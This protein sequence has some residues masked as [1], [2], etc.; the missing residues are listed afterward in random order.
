MISEVFRKYLMCISLVEWFLFLESQ[1]C[2]AA[3]ELNFET[4]KMKNI[5]HLSNDEYSKT[6]C[7]NLKIMGREDTVKEE[8][9]FV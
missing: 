1:K 5:L 2:T 4:K 3:D 9:D 6:R 7:N 8:E